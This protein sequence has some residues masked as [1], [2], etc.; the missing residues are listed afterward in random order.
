MKIQITINGR[1]ATATLDDTPTAWDFASLLP[2]TLT[3]TDY[4]STEKVSDL[5]RKLTQEGA[6]AGYEPLPGDITTYAPWGNL[7]IFY[8][9]FSYSRGLIRIGRIDSGIEA[10]NQ[11][12]SLPTTIEIAE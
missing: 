11:S 6:P 8:R 12:G 2:L 4:A 1:V 10:L 9:G 5:P 3:L 7:A